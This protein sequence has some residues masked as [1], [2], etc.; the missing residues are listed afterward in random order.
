[1]GPGKYLRPEEK[2][3]FISIPSQVLG[4]RD[5][6]PKDFIE[7]VMQNLIFLHF[8]YPYLKFVIIIP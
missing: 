1:M 2:N 8:F 4:L 3:M 5:K 6:F 7:V